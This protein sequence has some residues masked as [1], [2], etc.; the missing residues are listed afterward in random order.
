MYSMK[1]TAL[2]ISKGDSFLMEY[3][4][5]KFLI[6]TGNHKSECKNEVLLKHIKQLDVVIITHYDGDHVNGIFELLNNKSLKIKEVWLP[7]NFGRIE[8]SVQSRLLIELVKIESSMDDKDNSDEPSD[9]IPFAILSHPNPI[10]HHAVLVKITRAYIGEKHLTKI[11]EIIGLCRKNKIFIRWIKYSS[12]LS[13]VEIAH[14]FYG[15]NCKEVKHITP[16]RD[17]LEALYFLSAI[18]HESLVFKFSVDN[19]PNILFTAD[20]GFEFINEDKIELNNNSV[21]TAPHHGSSS[22][23]NE[24]CYNLIKGRDLIYVRSSKTKEISKRF[25]EQS[26]RYC[27]KCSNGVLDEVILTYKNSKWYSSKNRCTC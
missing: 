26:H 16:F 27:T 13:D 19:L 6:D 18:N 15:I 2:K 8:K 17:D 23:E 10:R 21:V 20:S 4:E 14:H 22:P 5:L 7:E 9:I 1:L 24:K 25:K 11:M 12:G 3:N